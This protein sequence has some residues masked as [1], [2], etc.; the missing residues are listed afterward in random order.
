VPAARRESK[1][2]KRMRRSMTGARATEY[3]AERAIGRQNAGMNWTVRQVESA[4]FNARSGERVGGEGGACE[5][6][7]I[8]ERQP[9]RAA[10]A[11]APSMEIRRGR[12]V[13]AKVEKE[14]MEHCRL[15]QGQS[16]A[17]RGERACDGCGGAATAKFSDSRQDYQWR[18]I[19]RNEFADCGGGARESIE[20]AALRLPLQSI[21]R[22]LLVIGG[23][24]GTRH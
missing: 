15:T 8:D 6:N 3:A 9:C 2:A 12:R 4:A 20:R 5:T 21:R 19:R 22:P 24:A 18:Q 16:M 14:P 1:V 17:A 13:K 7:M 11:A 23:A 10:F